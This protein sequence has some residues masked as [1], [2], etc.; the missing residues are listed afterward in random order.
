MEK[1]G[2]TLHLWGFKPGSFASASSP[3]WG[4]MTTGSSAESTWQFSGIKDFRLGRGVKLWLFRGVK[5]FGYFFDAYSEKSTSKFV[6]HFTHLPS[7]SR[8]DLYPSVMF[9][10]AAHLPASWEWSKAT[11]M[12]PKSLTACCC[13]DFWFTT[14]IC[15]F[16]CFSNFKEIVPELPCHSGRLRKKQQGLQGTTKGPR[17]T[18]KN[19]QFH[20]CRLEHQK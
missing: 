16:P 18:G 7:P 8:W 9:Q 3:W 11:G 1:P 14:F 6:P 13:D 5:W 19:G 10:V 2:F 15:V 12:T 20:G 4:P 17:A